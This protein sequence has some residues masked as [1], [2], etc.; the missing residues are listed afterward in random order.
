ML[1]LATVVQ[2]KRGRTYVSITLCQIM[3]LAELD[4]EC[5]LGN[6]LFKHARSAQGV[7]NDTQAMIPQHATGMPQ[8]SRK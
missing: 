7:S 5:S 1:T 4:Y 3:M 2:G 6:V 8:L